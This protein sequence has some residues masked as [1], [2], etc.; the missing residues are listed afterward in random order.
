ML[1][2]LCFCMKNKKLV[3]EIY[4]LFFEIIQLFDL[5]QLKD[6]SVFGIALELVLLILENWINILSVGISIQYNLY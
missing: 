4:F 3:C 6:E 2:I 1:C 5:F